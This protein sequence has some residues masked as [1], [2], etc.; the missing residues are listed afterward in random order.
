M[1]DT[2]TLTTMEQMRAL[3]EPLRTRIL[4][5]LGE[6][7]MTTIQVAK[8][9][10][11]RHTK[12]YHHIG[13]LEGAGL[14][15]VV[16]SRQNRGTVEKYYV[17]AARRFVVDRRAFSAG[18]DAEEAR[19]GVQ[20]LLVGTLEKTI[21]EVEKSFAA[22]LFAQESATPGLVTHRH[23]RLTKAQ[24]EELATKLQSWIRDCVAEDADPSA[25]TYGLTVAVYPAVV[26]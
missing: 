6:R 20:S 10:N 1:N 18:P 14:I 21:A 19:A 12:L 8:R 9:L 3:A 16:E 13:V 7:P 4:E 24:L 11:E 25:D 26:D 22:G 17:P 2:F 23:L 5:A 15:E